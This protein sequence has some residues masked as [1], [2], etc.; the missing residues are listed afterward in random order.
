MFVKVAVNIPTG[1]TFVY[2]VPPDLESD[3]ALGKR[4]LVH[5]GGRTLTGYILEVLATPDYPKTK[6]LI[7]ILDE[8]PLFDADDLLFYQWLSDYYLQ[9]IGRVL[10]EAL[11]AG[12]NP[13]TRRVIRLAGD[14]EAEPT[15]CF[16]ADE[17]ELLTFLRHRAEGVTHAEI[18]GL[19]SAKAL[20]EAIKSLEKRNLVVVEELTERQISAGTV[21]CVAVRRPFPE[22]VTL[23][24]RQRTLLQDIENQGETALAEL[25]RREAYTPSLFRALREK[26]VLEIS[27]KDIPPGGGLRGPAGPGMEPPILNRDQGEAV[28]NI[29]EKLAAST[30]SV[31]LLHGVTGSGKTEV[32]L[33]AI[34]ETLRTGRGVLYLVPEIALTAQLL[35]RIGNRFPLLEIAVWHSDIPKRIRYDQWKRIL[36]GEV[37]FVVGARSAVFAPIRNLGLIIV[38]EEHDDSYKQDERTPYNGR[39]AAIVKGKQHGATVVLGSA[40]PALPTFYNAHTGKYAYLSLPSR[41]EGRPL[42]EVAVVAMTKERDERG[43]IPVF[44]RTLLSAM[45][46]SLA[47]GHQILLFLNRRG[48]H[49]FVHCPDCGHVFRC[50]N[51]S[52]SLTYHSETDRLHCHYCDHQSPVATV[53]SLCGKNRIIRYG[54]GT[55]RLEEEVKKYFPNAVIAR[56]DRD[57]ISRRGSRE[58]ILKRL[59]R[60][61]IDILLGTQMI[62][63]GHDFPHIN[64]IGVISADLSLNMP[65]FRAAER[66]FQL[67]TQVS[68]RSGRGETPGRV[69]IQT[70]NPDHYAIIRARSHDYISFY[71]DEMALRKTLSFPPFSRMITL[72][73][74]TLHREKGEKDLAVLKSTLDSLQEKERRF[75][76]IQVM[77]PIRSP[78]EKIRGRHRWQILLKGRETGPLHELARTILLMDKKG[79]LRITADVDPLNF[80]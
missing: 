26:G 23:T 58:D 60:R 67:L 42:P 55:E 24:D 75:R 76:H 30:F 16:T 74:S 40:T 7:R 63:K 27:L 37:R 3:T 19:L 59:E 45:E 68:G 46:D 18:E 64:L 78:I 35:E 54:I 66:T 48:F 57:S 8:E 6:D 11:P 50:S 62:T 9:P 15:E 20:K 36:R 2:R 53:C 21:K 71:E 77:G 38:D 14:T 47:G 56:M 22:N 43:A 44:S 29:H 69:V 65:D 73:F 1:R 17:T 52:V 33:R 31:C 13:K 49:T 25:R 70:L 79:P 61:D 10:S 28:Q 80:M 72:H 51:C 4:A 32:Y 34:G 39:D 41:V 12:I 5:F